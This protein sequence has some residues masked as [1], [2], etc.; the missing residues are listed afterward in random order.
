VGATEI[1][2][3]GSKLTARCLSNRAHLTYS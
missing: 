3:A 2:S 1:S